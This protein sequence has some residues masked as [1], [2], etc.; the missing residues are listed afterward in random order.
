MRVLVVD[1]DIMIR[2]YFVRALRRHV[3]VDV[4]VAGGVTEALAKF[5]V[6]PFDIVISDERM[7]DGSG[8]ALLTCIRRLRR[9]RCILMSAD[10]V[11]AR[12]ED[13]YE[14]FFAKRGGLSNVVA[15]V[16]AVATVH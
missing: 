6:A 4:D 16:H 14:C 15:W 2:H 10:D 1:D 8:R 9:C 7:P 3:N 13:C 5:R 12:P 11:T